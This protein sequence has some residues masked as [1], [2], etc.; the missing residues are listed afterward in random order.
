MSFKIWNLINTLPISPVV[1]ANFEVAPDDLGNFVDS[2]ETESLP[3]T[4][5]TSLPDKELE[6]ISESRESQE[7][8]ALTEK[9]SMPGNIVLRKS[10]VFNNP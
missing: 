10:K 4:I 2:M 7:S 1:P 6:T 8:T 3:S 9:L 5:A